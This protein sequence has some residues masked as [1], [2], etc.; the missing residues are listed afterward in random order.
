MISKQN[1]KYYIIIVFVSILI[2]KIIDTPNDF[3]LGIKG[4][5]SFFNPFLIGIL[6]SLL[7]NP[8]VTF[9]EN[10]FNLNRLLNIFTAYLLLLLLFILGFKLFIPTII[11]TLNTLIKELP[12][13]IDLINLLLKRFIENGDLPNGIIPHIQNSLNSILNSLIDAFSGISSHLLVYILTITS[14]VFDFIMG[15]ILSLY[16]LYDKEKLGHAIKKLI[17]ACFSKKYADGLIALT[18]TSHDI[19]YHYL[20]G[21]LIDASIVGVIS[22]VV[23][24]FILQIENSLF[25]SFIIFIT[26]MIPYFGPFIGAIPPI[27]M[28]LIYNPIKALWVAIFIIVLQ[29]LDGNFIAPKVMGTQVGLEPIWIISSVLIG[30]S[31]FGFIGIFL[32]IPAAALI[33]TYILNYIEKK[34][35]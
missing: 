28:T 17:Y 2:Y 19:F 4:L 21:Q 18:R 10:K 12:N 34:Q 22:F 8:I 15:I 14:V 11:K 1:I 35:I 23:F 33:K 30:G 31:L 3:I 24:K 13:Y 16:M 5:I 26:N 27:L 9:F 6:L 29:Q 32:C 25:L 7:L 20:L